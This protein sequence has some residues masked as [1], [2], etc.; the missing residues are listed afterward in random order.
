L[1]R[2]RRNGP[3]G[4]PI[5]DANGKDSSV[6]KRI[7]AVLLMLLAFFTGSSR[8]EVSFT[9]S[10]T[11]NLLEIRS[12]V[13]DGRPVPWHAGGPL[14]LKPSP[15]NISFGFGHATNA[16][17]APIRLR[18]KLEGYDSV[19]HEGGGEMNL[20][21]RFLDPS[22]DLIALKA[23]KVTGDSV[24]WNGALETATLTHRR[25]TLIVPPKASRLQ[26]IISSAGPPSTVGILVVDDLVVSRLSSSNRPA[27]VLLRS[28]FGQQTKDEL[29]GQAPQGWMRDGIRPGMAI[30][31][32]LGQ[33]PRTKAFAILDDDG[34]SHAEWHNLNDIS[35]AVA[36]GEQLLI[37]WNELFSMGVSDVT[38]AFYESLPHGDF[39]FRV[40]ETT[41]LGIPTGAEAS[42]RV[43][44]PLPF[45][46][47]PWFW[48]VSALFV[49]AASVASGRYYTW[50]RMR[51]EV[52]RL[53]QQRLLEQERL[54]IA[55]N[56]HD[57][58][59]ARVTQISLLSGMAQD[60]AS[61]PEEARADFANVSRMARE[62]VSALYETVWAVN[63]ENDNLDALG[64]YLC[65]MVNQSCVQAQ[66]RCRLHVADLPRDVQVSSQ[67]RHNITMAVKEAV[68]NVIK[69]AHA[70]EV[71]LVVA[72]EGR[73]L[74]V[75]IQDDGGGFQQTGDSAGN[76]LANM[77]RRLEDMGGDC[78]IESRAGRGTTVRMRL[79]IRTDT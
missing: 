79:E 51:R 48:G 24:G 69:H 4:L 25:E 10:Q 9:A 68:H 23:F 30:I 38:N 19:W 32:E 54:R 35:P 77:K 71:N 15:E 13:V 46:R 73:L 61:F 16:S 11:T 74:T 26:A 31:V 67:T 18:Y 33:N 14:L 45:W 27:V 64:N 2:A 76:G 39:R 43:R 6:V 52:L 5:I 78:S 20:A 28:P 60:D 47:M 57:D 3:A 22:G 8:A 41:P 59:G 12:V 72:F 17:R 62:L 75:S 42:L 29:T 7:A 36:P 44:V 37:E 49:M 55:Q 1:Y 70:S 21:V 50:H 53:K 40:A 66:L 63:P 65:Q 56:I 58:L 34:L